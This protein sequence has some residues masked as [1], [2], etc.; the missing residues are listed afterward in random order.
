MPRLAIILGA[1]ASFDC[2]PQFNT[3]DWEDLGRPE[4]FVKQPE[5]QPPIVSKMLG[6]EAFNGF[7]NSH[8]EAA[9]IF[10]DIRMEVSKEVS[11]EK[12]LRS[13]WESTNR[14]IRYKM[15]FVPIALREFFHRVSQDYTDQPANHI[16]LVGQTVGRGITTA[17]VTVNYDTILD[18]VL[19]RFRDGRDDK[20]L[21]TVGSYVSEPDWLLVKLHGS[22]DW[23]YR[24]G[25]N[26]GTAQAAVAAHELRAFGRTEIEVAPN[27]R[28]LRDGPTPFYPALALPVEGKFGFV[29]PPSHEEALVRH[30]QDCDN[31]LFIGF[32][33]RDSDLLECLSENVRSVRRL[34][35]VTGPGDLEDVKKRLHSV[36]SFRIS[37]SSIL[38]VH[39]YT[40]FTDFV[41]RGLSVLTGNVLSATE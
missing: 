30:L 34:W 32:S 4:H 36:A 10:N 12:V 40:S 1:G 39:T 5:Y 16:A 17:F 25:A 11:F 31:F 35:I 24:L 28:E 41:R 37:L 38:P 29:C 3:S 6:S 2:V 23:G 19:C 7:L 27:L 26:E 18:K 20:R 14:H 9:D 15:R 13:R 21:A 8:L 22:V 33:A